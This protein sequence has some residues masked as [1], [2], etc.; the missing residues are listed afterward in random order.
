MATLD[1]KKFR[2]LEDQHK[3]GIV[4]GLKDIAGTAHRLDVDVLL[5]R[6]AKTF[7]LFLIALQRL[8][9]MK[10]SDI[11]SYYQI[12][13]KCGSHAGKSDYNH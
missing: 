11:M 12:A 13:G 4:V 8:K 1:R 7:N 9:D 10:K 5:K 2:D 6:H 3:K